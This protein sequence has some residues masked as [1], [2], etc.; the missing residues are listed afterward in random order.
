VNTQAQQPEALTEEEIANLPQEVADTINEIT[1]VPEFTRTALALITYEHQ[2]KDAVFPVATKKGMDEAKEARATLR[3]TRTSIEKRRKELTAPLLQR[4]RA[5]KADG[6]SIMERIAALEQPI[7]NQI[8]AHEAAIE[9]ARL[10]D[11]Q[12]EQ[13]RVDGHRARIAAWRN[14][15]GEI[16]GRPLA[17]M[18]LALKRLTEET[19][20]DFA[21]FEEFQQ[22]AADAHM[23][24]CARV[25]EMV[26]QAQSAEDA[27]ERAR[28]Q[29][30]ELQAMRERNAA[31][32][33]EA[34]ERRQADARRE[35]A[36]REDAE[37]KEREAQRA[38][39]MR[40]HNIRQQ[41]GAI[42][43][44]M[45]GLKYMSAEDL[46]AHLAKL[47]RLDPEAS[48]FDFQ[49]FHAEAVSVYKSALV[50]VERAYDARLAVDREV[51]EAEQQRQA[52][53]AESRRLQQEAAAKAEEDRKA[54]LTLR[55]AAQ[56]LVDHCVSRG[57]GHDKPVEDL[58]AVLLNSEG[59]VPQVRSKRQAKAPTKVAR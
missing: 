42:I 48:A 3:T 24:V 52:E 29:E 5:L 45:Q 4:Q 53:L 30:A 8:K 44:A 51:A 40:V 49:E 54:S 21:V 41:I 46:T 50:E 32:E 43:Y 38:E 16:A 35:Q 7:D 34:E 12:K 58:N 27:A 25:T 13:N 39:E 14:L 17:G 47:T 26:D 28:Q 10:A 37:R 36:E 33:R 19:P 20:P 59:D 55:A 31:L 23:A 22:E 6:D 57:M 1:T 18:R 2:Y 11:I 56:A 15:P 9:A